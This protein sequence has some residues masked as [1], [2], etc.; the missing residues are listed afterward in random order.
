[1]MYSIHRLE[2]FWLWNALD[3]VPVV[4]TLK[5]E[6]DAFVSFTEGDKQRAAIKATQAMVGGTLDVLTFDTS[7][8]I[9][10]VTGMDIKSFVDTGRLSSDSRVRIVQAYYQPLPEEFMD[11]IRNRMVVHLDE[12]YLEKSSINY[13]EHIEILRGSV[14]M[15]LRSIYER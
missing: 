4:S 12:D 6:A 7:G 10:N 9:S 8:A 11:L 13:D 1:M 14:G 5:N 3:Y 2:M 15:Y